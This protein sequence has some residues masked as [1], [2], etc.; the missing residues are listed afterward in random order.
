MSTDT[1]LRA[2]DPL[3]AADLDPRGAMAARVRAGATAAPPRRA[4]AGERRVR[5]ALA[6]V[7]A[8][9]LAAVAVA[10][11]L[12]GGTGGGPAD[13][14]A[15]LITAAEKTAAFTSG[16]ITWHMAFG[17]PSSIYDVDAVNVLRYQGD[18]V[19]L[20][21]TTTEHGV[22]GDPAESV[23]RGGYRVVGGRAFTRTDDVWTPVETPTGER[24][25]AARF[26]E[27]LDSAAAF[28]DA[29]RAAANVATTRLDGAT[30]Y[31]ATVDGP[32]VP[33]IYG[34]SWK[35]T[36]T[37]TATVGDDGV[38]RQLALRSATNVLEVTFEDLGAPQGIVAP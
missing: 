4:G 25:P 8:T 17:D 36:V 1:I 27:E 6:A 19:D 14:R 29:V 30:G 23:H 28:A 3:D 9:A 18:D 21:A 11:A 24:G 13:A 35:G 5:L 37:L 2:A 33:E 15:A 12:P 34:P 7:S 26:H 10:L 31:T 16:R 20:D 38:V 32:S 22:G